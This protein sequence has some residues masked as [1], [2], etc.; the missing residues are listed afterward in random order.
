MTTATVG[1]VDLEAFSRIFGHVERQLAL[2]KP[3]PMIEAF[4]RVEDKDTQELIPFSLNANQRFA[5]QL[6]FEPQARHTDPYSWVIVKDRQATMTS[7][8]E[9]EKFCRVLRLPNVHVVHT[10]QDTETGKQLRKRLDLFKEVWPKPL[11]QPFQDAVGNVWQAHVVTD[12]RRDLEV[13]HYRNNVLL[14]SSSYL[15]VSA[16]EHEFGAG[17]APTDVI[18]DEYDLYTD[19]DLVGRIEN[20]KGKQSRTTKLSTP[21]GQRQL[22]TDYNDAKNGKS[23]E[24]ALAIFWFQNDRNSMRE[25]HQLSPPAYA[26]QFDLLPEHQAIVDSPEWEERSV[27]RTE[28]EIHSAFRWWEWKRMEIRRRLE[29]KGIYDERKVMNEMEAEHCSNDRDCWSVGTNS[30]FD[31]DQTKFLDGMARERTPRIKQLAPGVTLRIWQ[32]PQPGMMYACGMDCAEDQPLGDAVAAYIKSATG[33]YCAELITSGQTGLTKISRALIPEL[34]EWGTGRFEPLFAPEVD[35]GLGLLPIEVAKDMGYR[36][37]WKIPR[38]PTDTDARYA[39]KKDKYGW[40]TQ[41]NK[42]DMKQTGIA[43]LNSGQVEVYSQEL[44]R[45]M[46][47]FDI[48]SP[49]HTSDRLM[50]YFITEMI[51]NGPV[52]FS[53][54][55]KNLAA[56]SRTQAT[57]LGPMLAA[58]SHS[59]RSYSPG[60]GWVRPRR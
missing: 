54:Q 22:F 50:A 9:A 12:S 39:T 17:I 42:E 23:G 6:I 56:Q 59:S 2:G 36:N 13:R 49:K 43:N 25:G 15:I 16:G 41:N 57:K 37:I 20:A 10:F 26:S 3:G 53:R 48:N 34:W 46:S 44:L 11:L 7:F 4:L 33:V 31:R 47:N 30:P 14:G 28:E 55:F 38:K 21:R 19:L 29:A 5:H 52:L 35:G 40:R 27:F 51:T 1:S 24:Q 8:F 60:R 58:G 32:P 45:D 18:Y